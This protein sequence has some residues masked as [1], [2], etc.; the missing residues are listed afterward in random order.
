MIAWVGGWV[1]G[2]LITYCGEMAATTVPVL[3]QSRGG[4][5]DRSDR[6][7]GNIGTVTFPLSSIFN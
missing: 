2:D 7:H 6:Q 4:E 1:G 3:R 5:V